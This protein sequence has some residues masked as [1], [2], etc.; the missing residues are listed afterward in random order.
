MDSMSHDEVA[1]AEDFEKGWSDD[2]LDRAESS[3]GP[4]LTDALPQVLARK[5][6]AMAAREG[7]SDLEIINMAL[8]AYFDSE[9]VA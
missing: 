3:W 4:G 8:A 7:V 1:T 2:R 5:V 9:D 6:E